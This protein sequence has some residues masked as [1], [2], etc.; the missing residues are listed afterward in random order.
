[1]P[2]GKAILVLLPISGSHPAVDTDLSMDCAAAAKT[3]F[4]PTRRAK[5]GVA[6][7]RRVAFSIAAPAFFR[8]RG[9]LSSRGGSSGLGNKDAG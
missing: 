4:S 1:M 9:H 8:G 3:W 2:V 6:I 7:A 5:S